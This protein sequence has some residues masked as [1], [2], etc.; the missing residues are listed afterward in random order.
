MAGRR[1][2]HAEDSEN[3]NNFV[4]LRGLRRFSALRKMHHFF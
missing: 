1:V 3:K 2:G 4:T